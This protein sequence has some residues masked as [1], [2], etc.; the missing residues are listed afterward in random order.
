MPGRVNLITLILLLDTNKQ[1]DTEEGF[2]AAKEAESNPW[3]E[4][5]ENQ[6][7]FHSSLTSFGGVAKKHVVVEQ[8]QVFGKEATRCWIQPVPLSTNI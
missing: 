1:V 2:E 7:K 4:R 8:E 3:L 5:V 6:Y